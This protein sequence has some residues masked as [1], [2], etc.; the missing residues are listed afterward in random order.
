MIFKNWHAESLVHNLLLTELSACQIFEYQLLAIN[1]ISSKDVDEESVMHSKSDNTEFMTYDNANDVADKLVESLLSSY[2]N[3]LETS[4]IGSD[5]NYDSVQRL[6][7]RCHKKNF[8]RSGSYFD[9]P[10]W[11][12]KKKAAI[13][14]KNNDDKCFQHVATV[15]LFLKKTGWH[16]ERVP[17]MKPFI[18][19]YNWDGIKYPS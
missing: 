3:D 1:F 17:N 11:I 5:F 13:N 10:D 7:Y 14:P 18:N 12:K 19:K 4:M 8:K 16:P 15:A 9:S 6:Y 2:Q